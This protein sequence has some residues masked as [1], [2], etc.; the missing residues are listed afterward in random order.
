MIKEFFFN[1]RDSLFNALANACRDTLR[2]AIEEKQSASLL[3]SGGS[4]PRPLY[5]QL[6]QSELDWQN[7]T[8]A[9]VDE[10]WVEAGQEG[11]NE[12]FIV[13]NLIC[14]QA[15]A[16]KFIPMK[17]P[18]K[19]AMLGQGYCE[20]RYRQLPR[21][22]DVTILG[23]GSDGHTASLFPYSKGLK[24]ALDEHGETICAAIDA[25][26]SEVTGALTERMS[27]SLFGLMQSRQLHLLI[28]GDEKLAVYQQALASPDVMLTPVSAVLQQ[29]T[30]PVHI[31]WAP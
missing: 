11:S 13:Q 31:Y 16:A 21:P 15:A 10:R 1:D 26:R 12:T 20:R 29:T 28:T 8:V 6:S 17:T 30:V 22:F 23:M 2:N 25:E 9:L 5:Q 4:T 19:T 18:E 3:V 24:E 27:L 14:N 7:V